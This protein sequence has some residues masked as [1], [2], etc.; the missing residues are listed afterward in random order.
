MIEAVFLI[1][2]LKSNS[3]PKNLLYKKANIL[4]VVAFL[5]RIIKKIFFNK[6]YFINK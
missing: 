4:E 3:L 6:N 2:N 5:L 1:K